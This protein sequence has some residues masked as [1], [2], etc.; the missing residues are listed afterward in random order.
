ML[1]TKFTLSKFYILAVILFAGLALYMISFHRKNTNLNWTHG[2]NQEGV[3]VQA[4]FYSTRVAS[5]AEHG[6]HGGGYG[7]GDGS[8][9][10]AGSTHEEMPDMG[11]GDHGSAQGAHT[12]DSMDA[13]RYQTNDEEVIPLLDKEPTYGNTDDGAPHGAGTKGGNSMRNDS[14]N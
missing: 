12:I 11:S 10:G 8:H 7:E 3:D 6:G 13:N 2:Y 14:S 5:S 1:E 9:S 4:P